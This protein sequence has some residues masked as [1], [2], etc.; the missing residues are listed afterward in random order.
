MKFYNSAYYFLLSLLIYSQVY[1]SDVETYASNINDEIGLPHHRISRSYSIS[2]PFWSKNDTNNKTLMRTNSEYSKAKKK[3]LGNR[4]NS[5]SNLAGKLSKLNLWKSKKNINKK[6]SKR[7]SEIFD[8]QD[9]N[10]QVENYIVYTKYNK[11]FSFLL[12]ASFYPL[13]IPAWYERIA[14]DLDVANLIAKI[15]SKNRAQ[16]NSCLDQHNISSTELFRYMQGQHAVQNN[17]PIEFVA[18]EY[19]RVQGQ[20]FLQAFQKMLGGNPYQSILNE[21]ISIGPN[22][23]KNACFNQIEIHN[24]ELI[25]HAAPVLPSP[26]P[27]K[28]SDHIKESM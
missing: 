23:I 11:I 22:L 19:L 26:P 4:S 9:I 21:S 8:Y 6:T 3:Y 15:L 20:I 10:E 7:V 25:I 5:V 14:S 18:R 1:A 28:K 12:A 16:L 27:G 17:D 24:E 13:Q 2:G